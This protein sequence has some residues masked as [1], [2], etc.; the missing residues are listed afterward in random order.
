MILGDRI[1][2]T[3]GD[4]QTAN[5]ARLVLDAIAEAWADPAS[6]APEA[7]K[8]LP[9]ARVYYQTTRHWL[10]H[11]DCR[12]DRQFGLLV[13][14]HFFEL[15]EVYVASVARGERAETAPHWVRYFQMARAMSDPCKPA[16]IWRLLYLGFRAHTRYDLAEAIHLAYRD[17]CRMA[18]TGADLDVFRDLLLGEQT[19]DLFYGAALDYLRT[20]HA[21]LCPQSE[22]QARMIELGAR[23]VR[24]LWL[25]AFQSWRRA[26]WDDASVWIRADRKN[27]LLGAPV[28]K[29]MSA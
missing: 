10:D 27:G 11:L 16:Q 17:W 4:R 8:H 15:Y 28:P 5:R 23:W 7:D 26:A 9:F 3:P 22:H 21:G 2:G 18:G 19:D 29:P 14:V 25:P 1:G 13:I 20:D 24:P 12:A 6:N